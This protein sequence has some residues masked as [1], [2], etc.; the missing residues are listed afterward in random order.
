MICTYVLFLISTIKKKKER[1]K[2]GL[3]FYIMYRYVKIIHIRNKE[4]KKKKTHKYYMPFIKK[5]K[6]NKCLINRFYRYIYTFQT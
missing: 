1:K 2:K 4:K 5:K 6:T 3:S